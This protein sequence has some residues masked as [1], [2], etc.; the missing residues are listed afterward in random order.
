MSPYFFYVTW[1]FALLSSHL[2]YQSLPA[3]FTNC[4]QGSN[5]FHQPYAKDSE[6]FLRHYGYTCSM[7]LAPSYGRIL[8]CMFPPDPTMH[9]ASC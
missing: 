8:K 9:K 6:V 7:L 1:R 2:K 4:F 3:I 5:T